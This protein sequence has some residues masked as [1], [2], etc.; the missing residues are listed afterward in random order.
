MFEA[1]TLPSLQALRAEEGSTA[2]AIV[3]CGGTGSRL[4]L[5]KGKVL[6]E[7]CGLPLAAWSVV[8]AASAP[9]LSRIVVVCRAEDETELV[10]ALAGL[11]MVGQVLFARA[12]RTRQ[13]SVASG[14]AYVPAGTEFVCVH[15][16][17][18]PLVRP[19]LFEETL[20]ALRFD[21]SLS[22]AIAA[23]PVSDTLKE[24]ERTLIVGTADRTRYWLAQTPQTFRTEHLRQALALA[25]A[26]GW[27]LTDDAGLVERLGGTVVCVRST[28]ENFKV[29]YPEDLDMA[30]VILSERLKGEWGP[31][32]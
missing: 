16:G 7:L 9:S 19:D 14:L 13:A 29:T 1:E 26:E 32:L 18:R 4:G 5:P 8:A 12:G 15:D 6:A 21:E 3:V 20:D 25:E 23:V 10:D 31:E 17:A 27:D 24:C 22:G 30:R 2:A 28:R 11:P